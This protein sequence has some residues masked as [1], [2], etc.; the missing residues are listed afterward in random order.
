MIWDSGDPGPSLTH[1]MVSPDK[2]HQSDTV[3]ETVV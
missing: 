1:V 2:V 3:S